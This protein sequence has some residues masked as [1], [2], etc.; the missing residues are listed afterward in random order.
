M[1]HPL[2]PRMAMSVVLL[3]FAFMPQAAAQ[4][5]D[6]DGSTGTTTT[7]DTT[8]KKPPIIPNIPPT[9]DYQ[10]IPKLPRLPPPSS[11]LFI[12]GIV[13]GEDG[14][15]PPF[16]ATIEMDCGSSLTRQA[17]VDNDGY[18]SFQI[19]ANKSYGL[20]MPDASTGLGRDPFHDDPVVSSSQNIDESFLPRLSQEQLATK[21]VGCDLRAQLPGYRSTIARVKEVLQPGQ[22]DV[23]IIVVYPLERVKGTTVSVSSLMAPKK[24]KKGLEQARKALKKNRFEEAEARLKSAVEVYPE[25]GEAWYELGQLYKQQYRDEEAREAYLRAIDADGLYVKP[26]IGLGWLASLQENWEEAA[27]FTGQAVGLDPITFPVAHFLNAL[28]NLNLGNFDLAE[29]SAQQYQRLDP[30]C[31]FPSVFLILSNVYAMKND[32]VRSIEEMRNY[33][34]HDPDGPNAEEV[35]AQLEEKL[36]NAA[37]N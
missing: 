27:N 25:Y 30:D 31:R 19:G 15:A 28:A 6:D 2:L 12:S 36:A 20:V 17:S 24:A 3:L 34:E 8:T 23:G 10:E 21:L 13:V 4:G 32:S 33:L 11:N 35:R 5:G 26:Y 16:G 14:E 9:P 1:V 37:V 18:F 22:N 29:K 7:D